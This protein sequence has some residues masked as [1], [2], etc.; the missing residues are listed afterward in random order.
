MTNP[1][2][3]TLILAFFC[4][5]TSATAQTFTD[6]SH[7]IPPSDGNIALGSS[8]VDVNSDGNVDMYRSKR[9]LIRQPDGTLV[10]KFTELGL[11]EDEGI[12]FGGLF[13]DYNQDGFHDIFLMNLTSPSKI[14]L[15]RAGMG[16][17]Q[18][19][20]ATG[21]V[22]QTLVQGSVWTDFDED[23]EIDLFVGRDLGISSLFINNPTHQFSD[24]SNQLGV[25]VQAV[26]GATASDFDQDGDVDIFITQCF[27]PEGSTT[28]DNLLL[29]N[30]NGVLSNVSPARGII[31][32]LPSWGTVWLDY[33]NDGWLDIYVVNSATTGFEGND[34]LG[35]NKLYRNEAG[36]SFTDV[37]DEAGV[38]GDSTGENIAVSAADFDN[39]GWTD[40]VVASRD[41]VGAHLYRNNGD[42]TFTDIIPD[43]DITPTFSQSVSVADI[44][45]DGWIDIYLPGI[46]P[47]LFLNDGGENHY[48]K[49]QTRGVS[50]NLFGIGARLDLYA[51]GI[52]QVRE[53]RAGDGFMSQNHNF[54][55]HFGLGSASL[56]DSLIIRWPRGQVDR[57][58]NVE[59]DQEI[60][61]VEGLGINPPPSS[62]MLLEPVG[63]IAQPANDVLS[64]SWEPSTDDN[65]ASLSYAL[66]LL[67]VGVDTTIALSAGLP[68][69]SQD[70]DAALFEP[71]ETYRWTVSA[72]DGYSVQGTHFLTFTIG[73]ATHTEQPT[74]KP[75]RAQLLLPYPNPS[76][77]TVD[78][79]YRVREAGT[80]QIEV[81]NVLGHQ[82]QN[83]TD[84]F[85]TPGTYSLSWDG[86]NHENNR[87]APGVYL[88]R[89]QMGSETSS[90]F[91]IR[92]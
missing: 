27:A 67:G 19:N 43:L 56:V 72:S 92:Q 34:R 57:Y 73:N 33:D 60:T 64:F 49:V 21:I 20:E 78:I 26:Y 39:D 79:P 1:L 32:D 71:G 54:T 84:R 41:N 13:G 3:T 63:E 6:A 47:Q 35:Y 14:Y 70:V 69:P 66:H 36:L 40:L 4:I 76:H 53:I 52:R 42:G 59:A 12:V 25:G 48:L 75:D 16:Y 86:R 88:V 74:E 9:L 61:L 89:L 8:L 80:V 45:N 5:T 18:S 87:V 15:N 29:Q 22:D 81:F 2:L 11:D 55:A 90:T 91:I 44:D 31:D 38:A 37:S 46:Q 7:Q 77:V 82:V 23:G 85:H 30:N 58:F 50:E 65:P 10:D 83:L 24:I 62:A 28:S 68:E 51:N 17:V